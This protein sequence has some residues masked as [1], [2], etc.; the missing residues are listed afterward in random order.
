MLHRD[1][2]LA[3]LALLLTAASG[4]GIAA[5]QGVG[6]A[7]VVSRERDDVVVATTSGATVAVS[8]VNRDVVRIRMTPAGRP[9]R[10]FSY[11]VA[12]GARATLRAELS[13]SAERIDIR[14]AGGAHVAV[15]K[16]PALSVAVYD[17]Q[18]RLVLSD[19]AARPM[20][21][22]PANGAVEAT[23]QRPAGELY[24]GFGE[25]PLPLSRQQ[26]SF[27]FWNTD[28]GNY[29]PGSGPIYQ[30]IPFFIA[31]HAGLSYGVFFDN[32]W[33]S[34]FDM[35]ASDPARYSFGAGGGDLDYYVF[36]GGRER[37]PA[38][39]LGEYTALTGRGALPPLWA[40]GYQQSRYSYTPQA[41]VEEIARTFREKKIPADVIYLDIDYMDGY[42]IFTWSPTNF[43]DARGML[44]TLHGEGFHAV[45]IVDPGVKFDE[46]YPVY[47]SGR[48]HGVYVRDAAGSE[49]HA[50]VWPGVCAFPDFTDPQA[51][52]WWGDLHAKSLDEG[53]DGFWNDMNE[54]ATFPAE[55]ATAPVTMFDASKTFALDVRHAGDGEPGTHARYHNVFGMQMARA[56]FEGLRKQRPTQRPL[57]LTRAGYAG[58]QRYAAVWTGDNIASWEHLALTVPM[59]T[60]LSISGVPFVGADVGGFNG[61]PSAELYTRWLQAAVLT[62]FLRTHSAID[63]EPREPWTWGGDSERIN[64]ATIELRYRLLPYL[65]S[66]FAQAEAD[67]ITPLRPLWFEYPRDPKAALVD[68]QYLVGK[69]LLVAPVLQA[70]ST[71]RRIYFPVGSS[72][73]DWWDGSRHDGGTSEFV[74]APLDRL[75]LYV[76]VGAGV[77][78][79]PVIQHSGEA[80]GVALTVVVALGAAG[81]SRIFQDAGDGYGYRH[82][83]SRTI[84][85]AQTAAGVDLTIP[86]NHGFQRL[87]AVELVGLE[88]APKAVRLDGKI[89]ASLSFD[90]A[91]R[92]VRVPLPN[93]Q[94]RRIRIE[95]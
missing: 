18:E 82:G 35:G 9:G 39:V 78:T 51:R 80:K 79:E 19:D 23:K 63:T 30:T 2:T 31:S 93:E 55:D 70:G 57:V 37:S 1:H 87:A 11:A 52:A 34:H 40:L 95:M 69:D 42:R 48:E 5:W 74:A 12:D 24:Y 86:R 81:T 6:E 17:A 65:Y 84:E 27:A 13:E 4:P 8:F 41:K 89:V 66:L 15:Q 7:R 76:R 21:F 88:A 20:A 67:G 29:P 64:K 68:D 59:L 38:S 45:T 77:P 25:V 22:D 16:R 90:A 43:P 92:R 49:L 32:T 61:T 44:A 62:P 73:L 58:I 94:A 28:A 60:N 72:W 83:E 71:K 3:C 47:R 56:T 85:V 33:R 50:R 75:P 54:P 26:Q 14:V 91:T 46:N 53:V 10:D 36:T